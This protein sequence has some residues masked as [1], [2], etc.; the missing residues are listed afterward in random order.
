MLSLRDGHVP[1]R[2]GQPLRG[3]HPRQA[4][5]R[6]HPG[7]LRRHRAAAAAHQR[8]R[9]PHRRPH[10]AIGD[11]GLDHQ[12]GMHP[13]PPRHP[14]NSRRPARHRRQHRHRPQFRHPYPRLAGQQPQQILGPGHGE[15]PHPVHRRRGRRQPQ[16]DIG[17]RAARQHH[18]HEPAQPR[19]LVGHEQ[20]PDQPR[21]PLHPAAHTRPGI[22]FGPPLVGGGGDHQHPVRVPDLPGHPRPPVHPV[23]GRGQ[24]Q[25]RI[26]PARPQEH[27]QVP[28]QGLMPGI[29]LGVGNEHPHRLP[30]AAITRHAG[31][32]PS[33]PRPPGRRPGTT[34]P[35]RTGY[36]LPG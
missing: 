16:R 19:L 29:T 33:H 9:R 20:V 32:P 6:P 1:P 13:R 36:Y 22:P 23:T 12:L 27:P 14:H 21:L 28:D 25:L 7:H 31:P 15:L 24:V 17:R 4:Q 11:G 5:R 18:R 2:R 30:A 3:H 10:H 35:A 26:D 8:P 34:R